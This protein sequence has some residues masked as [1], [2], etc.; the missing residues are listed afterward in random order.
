MT[1]AQTT[2]GSQS[3]S[4]PE[5]SLATPPKSPCRLCRRGRL[6]APAGS[7][8]SGEAEGERPEAGIGP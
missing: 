3:E 1:A 4:A 5:A 7:F 8:S 6:I 2:T